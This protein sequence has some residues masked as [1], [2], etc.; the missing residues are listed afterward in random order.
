MEIDDTE[1]R[2][3]RRERWW[4][5]MALRAVCASVSHTLPCI[6]F[7]FVFSFPTADC[8]PFEACHLYKC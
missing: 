7:Y 3:R 1:K 5:R 6:M 8:N 2:R 4:V